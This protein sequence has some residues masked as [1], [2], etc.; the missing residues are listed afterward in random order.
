MPPHLLRCQEL[1]VDDYSVALGRLEAGASSNFAQLGSGNRY[2][3]K[4]RG[5]RK[6]SYKSNNLPEF[7]NTEAQTGCCLAGHN[8]LNLLDDWHRIEK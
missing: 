4:I 2:D 7:R 6:N 8:H 3:F 1:A 5:S